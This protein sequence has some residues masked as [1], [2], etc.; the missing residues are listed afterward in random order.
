MSDIGIFRQL[1]QARQEAKNTTDRYSERLATS[2][3]AIEPV[4]ALWCFRQAPRQQRDDRTTEF[5]N[6]RCEYLRRATR[7]DALV[8]K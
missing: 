8:F 3:C 7:K 4:F 5:D 2:G 1:P 6:G